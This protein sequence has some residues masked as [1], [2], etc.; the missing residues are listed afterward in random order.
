MCGIVV[1]MCVLKFIVGKCVNKCVGSW[2]MCL[3]LLCIVILGWVGIGFLLL[4]FFFRL[5]SILLN[6]VISLGDIDIL[7]FG[8]V[9]I[10]FFLIM[11]LD[12]IL[13]VV[14]FGVLVVY[15]FWVMVFDFLVCL[16]LVWV[17][18][19]LF[20]FVCWGVDVCWLVVVLGIGIVIGCCVIG[21][22][23]IMVLY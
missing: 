14:G 4:F 15:F 17:I 5:D 22:G 2:L 10:M 11:F 13:L 23:E 12:L 21:V 18:G 9:L 8:F 7:L 20:K 1:Y 6:W 19:E 3:M 16:G